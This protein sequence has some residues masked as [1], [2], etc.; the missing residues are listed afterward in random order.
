M[1]DNGKIEPEKT[2]EVLDKERAER[3]AKEPHSFIE[4]NELICAAIRNPKSQ[5]GISILVGNCKR[6]ELNQA[7]VELNHRMEIARRQMDIEAEV[8][9]SK[10]LPAKG[11]FLNFARRR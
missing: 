6:S 3:F 9:H 4:V 2:Q 5:L 10:I 7:Q 1:G 11:S 8:N